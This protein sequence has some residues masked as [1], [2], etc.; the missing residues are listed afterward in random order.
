MPGTCR[1]GKRPLD[2]DE[3]RREVEK[4]VTEVIERT[5]PEGRSGGYFCLMDHN[6]GEVDLGPVL[7]GQV[8]NG[9]DEKYKAFCQEKA[10]R[11]SVLM[12]WGRFDPAA[13]SW[14]SRNER[15]QRWGGAIST[16]DHIFSFSG[17]PEEG[18]E[19]AMIIAAVRAGQLSFE[20][21]RSYAG[22][23]N[24]QVYLS[25]DWEF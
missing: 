25:T 9:K 21:A 10:H 15:K 14:Q 5:K 12:D 20:E 17:L 2:L 8:T 4:A 18:D 23:S 7:I 24:N 1:Q 19:A 22:T 11:L 6:T 3:V 16:G 13:T